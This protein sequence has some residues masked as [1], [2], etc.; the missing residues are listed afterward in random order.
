M[1]LLHSSGACREPRTCRQ[2]TAG[3]EAWQ[4]LWSHRHVLEPSQ[5]QKGSEAPAD[6]MGPGRLPSLA[7]SDSWSLAWS[8]L[9]RSL[10]ASFLLWFL[11]HLGCASR[12]PTSFSP[13]H[14]SILSFSTDGNGCAARLAFLGKL[15]GLSLLPELSLVLF[16]PALTG[17]WGGGCR[18]RA[19]VV[20]GRS[21][22]IQRV[23][24]LQLC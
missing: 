15:S 3:R 22:I 20:A 7:A 10:H 2:G 24:L 21:W 4:S 6:L 18:H 9:W 5:A 8:P 11:R 13:P 14:L 17:V 12:T 19:R 23:T 1:L 16:Q